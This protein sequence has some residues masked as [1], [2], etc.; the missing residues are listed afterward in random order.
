MVLNIVVAL[1][2]FLLLTTCYGV[3]RLW[4]HGSYNANL[5][6]QVVVNYA[7]PLF[8]VCGGVVGLVFAI[9][10][11]VCPIFPGAMGFLG[12]VV[13]S[14]LAQLLVLQ[15][16]IFPYRKRKRIEEEYEI[17]FD[18]A[19]KKLLDLGQYPQHPRFHDSFEEWQAYKR[20]VEQLRTEG[21]LPPLP[22]EM[23]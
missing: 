17:A 1:W 13:I 8:I 6:W 7:S 10:D 4:K 21:K 14:Y 9:D 2:V 15:V 18:R 23:R 20:A 12:G 22:Q 19:R 5:A 11:N 3:Y 16:V